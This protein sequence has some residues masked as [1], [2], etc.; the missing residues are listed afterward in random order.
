MDQFPYYADF[1]QTTLDIAGDRFS[2]ALER[3]ESL[4]KT[5]ESAASYPYRTRN[6]ISYALNLLREA[7]LNKQLGFYAQELSLLNDLSAFIEKP[8]NAS[9]KE[10]LLA[11]FQKGSVDLFDYIQFR[12]TEIANE[13]Q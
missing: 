12:K 8:E 5:M 2:E 1:A 6:H 4:R 3:T 11:H 13:I 10:S 9:A 7:V